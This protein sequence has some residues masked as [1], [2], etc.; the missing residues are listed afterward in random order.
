M[1]TRLAE[2]VERETL[3]NLQRRASLANEHDRAA[4]LAN[5]TAIA[6]PIEQIEALQV[7]VAERDCV[8][9]GFA[10]IQ[11]RDDGDV[12]LDGLFVDP[13]IW[14]N[15]IGSA[16]VKEC[17]VQGSREGRASLARARQPACSTVLRS[18]RLQ[19]I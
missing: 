3:E 14:R 9:V 19:N 2:E 6:L 13:D 16:L 7:I 12:E 15:G 11:P 5:P 17:A 10:T 8:V 4:L 1:L 18:V